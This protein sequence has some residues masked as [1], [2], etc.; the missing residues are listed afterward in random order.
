M[1]QTSDGIE[2]EDLHVFLPQIVADWNVTITGEKPLTSDKQQQI[3]RKLS[4]M[5]ARF[6]AENKEEWHS[7]GL[8][9]TSHYLT[10]SHLEK[11]HY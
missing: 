9:W 10:V 5:F 4:E 3:T 1:P 6:L 11:H 2:R 7:L 8:V